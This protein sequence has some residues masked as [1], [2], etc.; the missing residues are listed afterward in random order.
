MTSTIRYTCSVMLTRSRLQLCSTTQRQ[1]K[2]HSAVRQCE[3]A[4]R[5]PSQQQRPE[6][7]N[8]NL[9]G[10]QRCWRGGVNCGLACYIYYCRMICTM[11]LY[12]CI[13]CV[14]VLFDRS[15]GF[16][17]AAFLYLPVYLIFFFFSQPHCLL[18]GDLLSGWRLG[19]LA[20]KGRLS[21]RPSR[22]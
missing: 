8:Y 22:F 17:A 15:I 18:S 13:L 10:C 4:H 9:R 14:R 6:S 5:T 21:R 20:S 7:E 12:V 3:S 11:L 1:K 19:G 2:P 16:F